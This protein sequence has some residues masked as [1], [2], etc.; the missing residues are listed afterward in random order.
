M[1]S[2]TRAAVA[3]RDICLQIRETSDVKPVSFTRN[4]AVTDECTGATNMGPT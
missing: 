1:S 3:L 4:P 2:V